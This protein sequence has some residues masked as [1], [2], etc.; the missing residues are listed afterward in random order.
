M[1]NPTPYRQA[2]FALTRKTRTFF[3]CDEEVGMIAAYADL[4]P[5]QAWWIRMTL[6]ETASYLAVAAPDYGFETGFL[7]A[8]FFA[9]PSKEVTR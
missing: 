3:D 8:R 4:D 2:V 1:A 6:S 9:A 7:A 5:F